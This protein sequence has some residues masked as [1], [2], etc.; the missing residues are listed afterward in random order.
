MGRWAVS[1]PRYIA[2]GG[3]AGART[4][5]RRRPTSAIGPTALPRTCR[6]VDGTPIHRRSYLHREIRPRTPP[7]PRCE[8]SDCTGVQ[9]GRPVSYPAPE[10]FDVSCITSFASRRRRGSCTPYSF[11]R[12]APLRNVGQGHSRRSRRRHTPSAHTSA[13]DTV[14]R[15]DAL[16]QLL[17]RSRWVWS[18]VSVGF[19]RSSI[20]NR[21]AITSIAFAA[22]VPTASVLQWYKYGGF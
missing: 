19:D 18:D 2:V 12:A 22:L 7:V 16:R 4:V 14:R 8:I 1:D 6:S 20:C 11:R 9:G 17:L 5:L 21:S 15:S 13:A 3:G 10:K